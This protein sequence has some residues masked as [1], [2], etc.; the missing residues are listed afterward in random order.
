M[1]FPLF[2]AHPRAPPLPTLFK[3]KF[4]ALG[5]VYTERT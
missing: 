4:L 1:T 5:Q 3:C 2:H